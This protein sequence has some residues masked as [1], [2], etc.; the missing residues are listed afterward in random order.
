MKLSEFEKRRAANL[1]WNA[2]YAGGVA[3]AV[4]YAVSVFVRGRRPA[5]TL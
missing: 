3:L 1:I 4:L 5:N 2:A